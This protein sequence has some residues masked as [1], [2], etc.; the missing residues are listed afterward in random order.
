MS[1]S[2][3]ESSQD[4]KISFDATKQHASIK[5][6]YESFENAQNRCG[7]LNMRECDQFIEARATLDKAIDDFAEKKLTCLET[8]VVEAMTFFLAVG[9]ALQ[10]KAMFTLEGSKLLLKNLDNVN[11]W[12]DAYK[13][14]KLKLSDM[15]A[16]K[17]HK[18][19]K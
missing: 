14:P 12:V 7:V 9:N 8:D 16:K 19:K 2:D 4:E 3:N 11:D 6:L 10:G 5:L 17:Q 13:S 18:K 15:K 1:A